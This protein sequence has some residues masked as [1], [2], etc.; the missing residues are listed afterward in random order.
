MVGL[1]DEYA[2]RSAQVLFVIKLACIG[3]HFLLLAST[4]HYAVRSVVEV[5]ST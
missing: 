3:A 4:S 5:E 1:I 2:L